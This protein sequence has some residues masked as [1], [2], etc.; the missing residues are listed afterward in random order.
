[1]R[2]SHNCRQLNPSTVVWARAFGWRT[3]ESSQDL[4]QDRILLRTTCLLTELQ[5]L[6]LL[7]T[8]HRLHGWCE[9]LAADAPVQ[10]PGDCQQLRRFEN[11]QI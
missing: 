9:L 2:L 8:S 6:N 3:V 11:C 10:P 5:G 4:A 1:M 7:M